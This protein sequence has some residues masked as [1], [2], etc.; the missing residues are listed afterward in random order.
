[1]KRTAF[2]DILREQ[3]AAANMMNRE[4][5]LQNE[6]LRKTISELNDTITSLR[7]SMASLE[8]TLTEKDSALT[9]SEN[10]RR[11]LA[12]ISK[13]VSEKRKPSPSVQPAD[14]SPQEVSKPVFDP[15]SRGNN[16]AKRNPHYELE[17]E[18]VEV[19]PDD[20]AFREAEA[21]EI[22]VGQS[23]RYLMIGPR[24]I[25]R[26]Y[27]LHTYK[28]GGKIYTSKAPNAPIQNSNYDGSFIAGILQL[29]Y[30]YS[31]PIERICKYFTECGFDAEKATLNGLIGKASST[32]ENLY[33]ALLSAVKEDN[34]LSGDETY[35]NVLLKGSDKSKDSKSIKKGYIW[36]ITGRNNKLV[37]FSYN[38]GSRATDV[39]LEM[40]KGYKGTIQSDGWGAYKKLASGIKR[41][42]C[43]QHCKRKFLD[44]EGNPDAMKVVGII[45]ELYHNDNMHNIGKARWTEMDHLKWR[46][47]YAPPILIRLKTE[48]VRIINNEAEYP[49]KSQLHVAAAY[50]LNEW[51]GIE[52][53]FTKGCYSLD[54]NAIERINRYISLSRRNSLFFGSHEGAK[55]AVVFYSI[56]CSCR[57]N[58]VN[59]F[60]YLSDVLN[61]LANIQ[62]T[63]PMEVYR[64]LLPDK[65][66]DNH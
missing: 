3:L 30:I 26:I 46:K 48:L 18:T 15:K 53:I 65:W 24:F 16:G 22:N 2:E 49:P 56:A 14:D 17:T 66:K 51:D 54:N 57:L 43:I 10:I 60:E 6:N 47:E 21:S 33:K 44:I 9:K 12:K 41:I 36:G 1:M 55:R 5:L 7:L 52:A 63:A 23:V 35:H 13:N 42:G 19:Y 20:P 62:P 11:G 61:R 27:N 59:T 64:Q 8:K 45:N 37:Y 58:K 34:Y 31:M 28:Q 40:M 50:M 32:C 4:L 29:R 38:K 25:K 39:L